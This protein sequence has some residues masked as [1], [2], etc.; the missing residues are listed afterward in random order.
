[1]FVTA[2][3]ERIRPQPSYDY[4]PQPHLGLLNYEGWGMADDRN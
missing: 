3:V 1:M 2:R 4:S